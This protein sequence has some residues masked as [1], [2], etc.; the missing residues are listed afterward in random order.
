LDVLIQAAGTVRSS[1]AEVVFEDE[2]DLLFGANLK[3]TI[4]TNQA[5]FR[6]MKAHG[7]RIINFGSASGILG[8]PRTPIYAAARGAVHSWTRSVAKGWGQYQITVNTIAPAMQTSL[9]AAGQADWTEE[10]K[11]AAAAALAQRVPIDGKLGD[12]AR[13]LVP[14]LLFLASSGARFI[15]GQII[16]V[17]GGLCMVGA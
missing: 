10:M 15:T 13:D 4:F 8:N 1:A 7:G 11:K 14:T 5:A 6:L 17:D 2:I 9:V 12:P 16:P 3:S